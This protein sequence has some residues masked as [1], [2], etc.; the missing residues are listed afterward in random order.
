MPSHPAPRPAPSIVRSDLDR[1]EKS[2]P[3]AP[4]R[5]KG[6]IWIGLFK[7]DSPPALPKELRPLL[8]PKWL[9]V[10]LVRYLEGT[11]RY[12][13]LAI[14]SVVRRGW[15][16]GAHVH[17]I[18]VD[19]EASLWGGR[20]IWGVPKE[21]ATFEWDGDL[22]R[23]TDRE[24]PIATIKVDQR[25]SRGPSLWIPSPCFGYPD[26]RLVRA[27]A[28]LKGRLA[29]PRMSI[30]EWSSRI[31]Y[32]LMGAPRFGVSA[33]P[34]TITVRAPEPIDRETDGISPSRQS[35]RAP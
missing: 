5:S 30:E 7:V 8:S 14:C 9:A 31:P 19:S 27:K 15:R 20:R 6:Q 10:Y 2:Y 11:L 32:R 1:G 4:W 33:S 23:V 24:G 13:E 16:Y 25:P 22:V 3:P 34:M 35:S 28:S 21:L 29:G 18:W 12:D 17:H 26:G